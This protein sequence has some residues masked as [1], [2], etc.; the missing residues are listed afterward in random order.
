MRINWVVADSTV[1]A[2][3]VDINVIKN[4]ASIWGSWR[5]WR[6]CSTDNVVCNDAGKARELLKRNMNEMC[7]M[8]IPESM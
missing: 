2:P 1:V 8:Y 7:N 5:T 6:G 3:D 4:I